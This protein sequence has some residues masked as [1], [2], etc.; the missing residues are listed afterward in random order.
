LLPEV[1]FSL[2]GVVPEG[3]YPLGALL[4]LAGYLAILCFERVLFQHKHHHHGDADRAD[5]HHHDHDHGDH[6][7][8][9]DHDHDHKHEKKHKDKKRKRVTYSEDVITADNAKHA[10]RSPATS[11]KT[12]LLASPESTGDVEVGATGSQDNGK[13]QRKALFASLLVFLMLTVH[14][15]FEGIVLGVS[16]DDEATIAILIAIISHKWVESLSLGIIMIKED[17]R[18]LWFI[19]LI[20]AFSLLTPLG[21]MIGALASQYA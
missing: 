12:P 1:S 14:S 9:H 5:E 13:F 3:G 10:Q 6:E 17:L 16:E 4:I 11:P 20:V 21:I 19:V 18:R 2:H 15:T 7:H 8:E